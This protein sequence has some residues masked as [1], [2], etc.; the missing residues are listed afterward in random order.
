MLIHPD[1]IPSTPSII[2]VVFQMDDYNACEAYKDEFL[3]T[4]KTYDPSELAALSFV[5]EE[6]GDDVHITTPRSMGTLV[7]LVT[8]LFHMWDEERRA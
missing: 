2:H 3:E 4:M 7:E 8:V 5:S 6:S 1:T